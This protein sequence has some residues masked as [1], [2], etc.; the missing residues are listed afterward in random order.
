MTQPPPSGFPE[1]GADPAGGAPP[2]A[3]FPPPPPPP[4]PG[5]FPG[6]PPPPGVLPPV[7]AGGEPG[8]PAAWGQPMAYGQPY[9]PP[10]KKKRTLLKVLLSILAVIIGLGVIGVVYDLVRPRHHLT[11]HDTAGGLTKAEATGDTARFLTGFDQAISSYNIK[12]FVSGAYT[13]GPNQVA[14]A[15]GDTGKFDKAEDVIN[16]FASGAESSGETLADY[17]ISGGAKL[18]CGTIRNIAAICGV[19][20]K[21]TVIVLFEEGAD[22]SHLAD[23]AGRLRP[24][25]EK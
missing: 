13:D 1:P 9:A 25:L 3:G 24:D 10:P 17:P 15:G 8:Q 11:L 4:P 14:V 19:A 23:I 12:H 20:D 7:T 5:G 16:G 18:K 22:A 2:P 6:G 21:D